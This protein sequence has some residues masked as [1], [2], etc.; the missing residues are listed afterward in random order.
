MYNE[1]NTPVRFDFID[2]ARKALT[3]ASIAN[4]YLHSDDTEVEQFKPRSASKNAINRILTLPTTASSTGVSHK[5]EDEPLSPLLASD[6]EAIHRLLRSLINRARKVSRERDIPVTHLCFGIVSYTN[7][8]QTIKAPLMLLPVVLKGST[9]APTFR[10]ER[11]GDLFYNPALEWYLHEAAHTEQNTT[12][13]KII[14]Q[15]EE[16]RKSQPPAGGNDA[17][18]KYVSTFA[19]DIQ[20]V[21]SSAIIDCEAVSIGNFGIAYDTI[22]RDL[23]EIYDKVKSD[24]QDVGCLE[25]LETPD[26]HIRKLPAQRSWW[27]RAT[28]KLKRNGAVRQSLLH[29]LLEYDSSQRNVIQQI[30]DGESLC[31]QG[32]PGTGKSQTIANLISTLLANKKRVL[33]I[34][35]KRT[36][37]SAVIEN[38]EP[39]EAATFEIPGNTSKSNLTKLFMTHQRKIS[40]QPAQKPIVST[41]QSK[42]EA[43][44]QRSRNVFSTSYEPVPHSS[45]TDKA[46]LTELLNT[47]FRPDNTDLTEYWEEAI[48]GHILQPQP[49]LKRL[50]TIGIYGFWHYW[51]YWYS[52]WFLTQNVWDSVASTLN[53]LEYSTESASAIKIRSLPMGLRGIVRHLCLTDVPADQLY[54]LVHH[55]IQRIYILRAARAQRDALNHIL[56][57]VN[58]TPQQS[59]NKKNKKYDE[60][61]KKHVLY[62]THNDCLKARAPSE[63]PCLITTPHDLVRFVSINDPKFDVVIIDEASQIRPELIIGALYRAKQCAVFGD[64]KQLPPT[65]FGVST[66]N[67]YEEAPPA[68]AEFYQH[69][70]ESALEWLDTN[71]PPSKKPMLSFFYRGP[72]QLIAAA[73][74][75]FYRDEIHTFPK[76]QLDAVTHHLIPVEADKAYTDAAIF[77]TVLDLYKAEIQ[78]DKHTVLIIASGESCKKS[79][80]DHAKRHSVQ[81]EEDQITTIE[82]V[83]GDEA[84]TVICF[85]D[86]PELRQDG[87]INLV[88]LGPINRRGGERRLNVAFSRAKSRMHLVTSFRADQIRPADDGVAQKFL[89]AYIELAN[90]PDG[91][92]TTRVAKHTI[93]QWEQHFAT[94]LNARDDAVDV[95]HSFGQSRHPLTWVTRPRASEQY[96]HTYDTD[97]GRFSAQFFDIR[98]ERIRRDQLKRYNWEGNMNVPIQLLDCLLSIS[99]VHVKVTYQ[100]QNK[101][102]KKN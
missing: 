33:F 98:D 82:N 79:L 58:Q 93:E 86:D 84:D 30:L 78:K 62:A 77:Y 6:S 22:I 50:K 51:G 60:A 73:N 75:H 32:P 25:L 3:D 15:K 52:R 10:I 64:L 13:S 97:Y 48:N 65:Q 16:I 87:N 46:T 55:H 24:N 68:L 95:H 85:F 49:L 80:L 43:S 23:S 44:I 67:D 61:V 8:A 42:L 4:P 1:K 94:V 47:A 18:D 19:A 92:K 14:I 28:E 9:T 57:T 63:Y 7:A 54:A 90:N 29:P 89:K 99:S 20:T 72:E 37:L 96:T 36:A 2:K 59:L 34:A 74:K 69:T 40:S 27:D 21:L 53:S 70:G 45:H 17:L 100:A 88:A 101:R 39:I 71:F 91:I 83:Q 66:V 12:L 102:R 81:I 41:Q 56:G 35:Q 31:V 38:L 26:S 76:P 5:L 11:H